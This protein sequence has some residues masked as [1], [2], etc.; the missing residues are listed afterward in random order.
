MPRKKSL[1][2][3]YLASST[4][5][6]E[7]V[8]GALGHLKQQDVELVNAR[9]KLAIFSGEDL[10]RTRIAAAAFQAFGDLVAEQFPRLC[11]KC[12]GT[13]RLGYHHVS[14]WDRWHCDYCGHGFR[15][16]VY[17][18]S[19]T[20]EECNVSFC[21]RCL[22]KT[23]AAPPQKQARRKSLR[24]QSNRRCAHPLAF[25]LEETESACRLLVLDAWG[26][27]WDRTHALHALAAGAC[28]ERRAAEKA[29][30]KA[31]KAAAPKKEKQPPHKAP[32]PSAEALHAREIA[33]AV[34]ETG[35]GWN[36]DKAD[37]QAG[38]YTAVIDDC[39]AGM[40]EFAARI[41]SWYREKP[42]D[43][44]DE[45]CDNLRF[46]PG[47]DPLNTLA[48][49]SHALVDKDEVVACFGGVLAELLC[50]RQYTQKPIDID[51]DLGW[52][53]VPGTHA[54]GRL[55]KAYEQ[56]HTD[57]DWEQPG[58]RNGSIF[59]PVCA[60]LRDQGPGGGRAAWSETVVR[61]WVKWLCTVS[62]SACQPCE[63]TG[64]VFRGLGG[65]KLDAQ[66]VELHRKLGKGTVVGWPALSSTSLD[67]EASKDYM[68]GT[69][70]NSTAKP[71]KAKPGTILF[72]IKGNRWGKELTALSQYP[73][74]REILWGLFNLLEVEA[75]SVDAGNRL[76][77]GKAEGMGLVLDVSARGPVS[78]SPGFY[79]S[80][81]HDVA[82]ASRRLRAALS[83]QEQGAASASPAAADETARLRTEL[84]AL[85]DR[86]AA[87]NHELRSIHGASRSE[88]TEIL[89]KCLSVVDRL[90][91]ASAEARH[92]QRC[93]TESPHIRPQRPGLERAHS[94]RFACVFGESSGEAHS[95]SQERAVHPEATS[96]P[97]NHS[98]PADDVAASR[99]ASKR[100]SVVSLGWHDASARAAELMD[101]IES[102]ALRPE[103]PNQ[104]SGR[105]RNA[106]RASVFYE[107]LDKVL[108]D[109]A[110]Q[111]EKAAA[112]RLVRSPSVTGAATSEACD[113]LSAQQKSSIKEKDESKHLARGFK[114]EFLD[115]L[116]ECESPSSRASERSLS[117]EN[118][119][120]DLRRDGLDLSFADLGLRIRKK[121]ASLQAALARA[122]H[123]I[124]AACE[125]AAPADSICETETG[126]ISKR[127][128]RLAS[129]LSPNGNSYLL[130]GTPSEAS[131]TY[132]PWSHTAPFPYGLCEDGP[133][134]RAILFS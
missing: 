49:T 69:A 73:Q 28:R 114:S 86:F 65:G 44:V 107:V 54:A 112:Q 113:L 2:L 87:A 66:V 117:R 74:E 80:V 37:E 70:V 68:R 59:G 56:Q 90:R 78:V 89:S 11:S 128:S 26:D 29:A 46:P 62:A 10:E 96:K 50:L 8:G 120:Q 110:A 1:E 93:D 127:S 122:Q 18:C 32:G 121:L 72:R 22:L 123:A 83:T 98:L 134:L 15:A 131:S 133:A 51:R 24:G 95:A 100:L 118:S 41:E 38:E 4:V 63:E 39:S 61:K 129:T 99:R 92:S 103:G 45:L 3:T 82:I 76:A 7:H 124:V 25:D 27:G 115:A 101:R 47:A 105:D 71:S 57:W 84:A 85:R 19:Q 106:R 14:P 9:K 109:I 60:A 48:V 102:R 55:A 132:A 23:C 21:Q 126:S 67:E 17:A 5:V 108:T 31:K 94:V 6:G 34:Q 116:C 81:R 33:K 30:E 104:Q 79:K 58:K 77:N 20:P 64:M 88:R 53:E 35:D 16:S 36:V 111:A 91:T 52:S 42:G 13:H 119:F 40:R 12:G 130:P 75:L 43:V 97:R 125:S